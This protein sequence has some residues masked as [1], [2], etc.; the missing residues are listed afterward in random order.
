MIMG[1]EQALAAQ[2]RAFQGGPIT[3]VLIIKHLS[4]LTI[5]AMKQLNLKSIVGE[6]ITKITHQLRTV[7]KRFSS[8]SVERFVILPTCYEDILGIFTTFTCKDFN[9][10]FRAL[11]TQHELGAEQFTYHHVFDIEDD[12]YCKHQDKWV[13][14]VDSGQSGFLGAKGDVIWNLT[15]IQDAIVCLQNKTTKPCLSYGGSNLSF[16]NLLAIEE[17]IGLPVGYSYCSR[18]MNAG[19][20]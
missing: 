18:K 1:E 9:A 16:V 17:P 7:L 5:R 3:L 4:G 14:A 12:L 15:Q 6:D 10:A 19:N 13:S 11:L 2:D 20:P 8:C